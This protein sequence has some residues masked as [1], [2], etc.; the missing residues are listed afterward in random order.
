[1]NCQSWVDEAQ[2]G[3]FKPGSV[4]RLRQIAAK[5][6]AGLKPVRKMTATED[7]RDA[8]RGIQR[9]LDDMKASKGIPAR[10][11]LNRIRAKYQLRRPKK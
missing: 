1:M 11:G 3:S 9:G 5:A 7:M 2:A 10:E 4:A 8:I 6:R